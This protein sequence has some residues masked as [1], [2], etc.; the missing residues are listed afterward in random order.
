MSSSFISKG[1]ALFPKEMHKHTSLSIC[2]V[3]EQHYLFDDSHRE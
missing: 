3:P 2:A 1:N